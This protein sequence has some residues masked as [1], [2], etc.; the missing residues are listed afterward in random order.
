M[1]SSTENSFSV[2]KFAEQIQQDLK[3][4]KVKL[5][6][7]PNI[8]LEALVVVN[9]CDSSV[10]DVAAIVDK[11]AAIAARLIRYANSPIY[12][13]TAPVKTVKSAIT[14]IGFD[15]VKNAI[16][17]LSMKD[18]F[19]T[20]HKVIEKRMETLWEHSV[21]VAAKSATLAEAFPHLNREEAMLAGLIHDVGAI[22]ILMRACSHPELVAKEAHLDKVIAALHMPIG[23]IMLT[24]WKFDPGLIAVAANHDKQDRVSK[25]EFVNYVDIVQVAN[26]LSYEG[27]NHPLASIDRKSIAA[28]KKMADTG[29]ELGEGREQI[30]DSI[31]KS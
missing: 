13:G 23:K 24:L 26:I 2:K 14:R 29:F 4:N 12:H 7:L 10:A 17:T 9:D 21:S 5:P 20:S 27:S 16:L 28:F 8:A 30:F 31:L 6:T 19:K 3:D 1:A 18:V 25:S 22:P 11:D 15:V